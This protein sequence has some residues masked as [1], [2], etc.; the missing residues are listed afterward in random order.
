MHDWDARI[1][2]SHA[3]TPPSSRFRPLTSWAAPDGFRGAGERHWRIPG[4]TPRAPQAARSQ[5]SLGVAE[6][7]VAMAVWLGPA[8]LSRDLAGSPG[9]RCSVTG[10]KGRRVRP[11]A[12]SRGRRDP[13]A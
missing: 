5:A 1:A 12:W 7:G 8:C 11:G 2:G 3:P 10:R 4:L 6:E 9:T 13:T